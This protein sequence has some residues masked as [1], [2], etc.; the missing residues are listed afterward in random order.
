TAHAVALDTEA[1]C[2]RWRQRLI[3]HRVHAPLGP[4]RQPLR[5]Q[6]SLGGTVD[7]EVMLGRET[8]A[9]AGLAWRVQHHSRHPLAG[10][11]L[12]EQSAGGLVV[13]RPAAE[14]AADV[15]PGDRA[16]V[17]VEAD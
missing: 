12:A 3:W 16:F 6:G 17:G 15:G 4:E 9:L 7:G 2:A 8:V 5:F 1:Q 10:L 14:W 11:P 13:D